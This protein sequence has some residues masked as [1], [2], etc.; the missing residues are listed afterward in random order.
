MLVEAPR[1]FAKAIEKFAYRNKLDQAMGLV[2]LND[3]YNLLFNIE[4][5]HIAFTIW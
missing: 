1:V 2:G 3:L 5:G 4:L